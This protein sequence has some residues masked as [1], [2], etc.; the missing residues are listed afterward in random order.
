MKR[1]ERGG[2]EG[3]EAE[4]SKEEWSEKEESAEKK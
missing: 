1:E 2:K 4:W 3:E